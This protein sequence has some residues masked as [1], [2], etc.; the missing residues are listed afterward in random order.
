MSILGNKEDNKKAKTQSESGRVTGGKWMGR[1][2]SAAQTLSYGL[3]YGTGAVKSGGAA[4]IEGLMNAM[5]KLSNGMVSE[6]LKMGANLAQSAGAHV[7]KLKGLNQQ[8]YADRHA[9]SLSKL[10]NAFSE[11]AKDGEKAVRSLRRSKGKSTT[12]FARV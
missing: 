3:G 7:E 8:P 11:G 4:A 10:V 6:A 1:V 9:P 2:I 5:N 12:H